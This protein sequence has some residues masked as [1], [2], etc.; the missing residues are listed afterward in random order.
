MNSLKKLLEYQFSLVTQLCPILWNPMDCSTPGFP[1]HHQLSELPQTHVHWV[2]LF[3]PPVTLFCFVNKF[4]C[5]YFFFLD[6]TFKQ[7]PM[8]VSLHLTSLNMIISRTIM[9]LKRALFH[10]FSWLSNILLYMYTTSLF[11]TPLFFSV[12]VI[13]VLAI[14]ALFSNFVYFSLFSISLSFCFL[15]SV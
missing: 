11:P 5:I 3:S 14:L 12:F 13:Q 9:L 10:S 7:Y 1:V 6:S 8:F 15:F 4:I 2:G